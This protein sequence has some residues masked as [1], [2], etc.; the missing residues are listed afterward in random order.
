MSKKN[1]R[2]NAILEKIWSDPAHP[3]GY[4][5]AKQLH[6]EIRKKGHKG[7]SL[8]QIE[9]WLSAKDAHTLH[10]RII[11]RFK[12]RKTVVPSV[13]YQA[14]ID[15]T[16]LAGIKKENN[17][18]RYLLTYINCFTRE[19]QAIPIKTKSSKDV[20]PAFGKILKRVKHRVRKIQSDDGV[21]F[22]C[23]AFQNYLKKNKMSHFTTSQDVKSAM[24]ERFHSTLKNR[25][26]RHFTNKNT[27]RYVEVLPSLLESYNN[28]I[29]RTTGY[30]PYNITKKNQKIVFDKLYKKYLAKQP[31]HFKFKINETVRITKKQNIFARGFKRGWTHE[32][33][34]VADRY[35]TSP[36]TYRLL[37]KKQNL[38]KG[39]FYEQ[40]LGKVNVKKQ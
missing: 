34:I 35:K 25:M 8:K 11:K 13:D 24:I 40:E 33:F 32:I 3:A 1:V 4:G 18:Y 23:N 22:L 26:W 2:I 38:L 5:S 19:A 21:E 6:T 37:D 9:E 10:R 39:S 28:R 12:R 36:P 7:T 20:I 29:C 14:Q 17:D 31:K 15:L 27:L 30:A 16:D